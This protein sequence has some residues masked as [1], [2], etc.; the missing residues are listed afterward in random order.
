MSTYVVSSSLTKNNYWPI[1]CSILLYIVLCLDNIFSFFS[2]AKY[3]FI[4]QFLIF[5]SLME[6]YLYDEWC[7]LVVCYI[8]DIYWLS[9]QLNI[10]LILWLCNQSHVLMFDTVWKLYMFLIFRICRFPYIWNSSLAHQNNK[11]L[12]LV[13][14][15]FTISKFDTV[16]SLSSLSINFL[17]PN[18]IP[19]MSVIR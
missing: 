15:R 17:L 11:D 12:M 8:V 1:V 5:L 14:L 2:C 10:T 18:W 16:Q 3:V 9:Y 19:N 6:V 4:Q 7:G 13:K